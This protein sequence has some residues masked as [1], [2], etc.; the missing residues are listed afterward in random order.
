MVLRELILKCKAIQKKGFHTIVFPNKRDLV[1]LQP[2][3]K[4][5]MLLKKGTK[6]YSIVK[7]KCPRCHQGDFFSHKNNF[8]LRKSTE[9]HENCSACN[10]KYMMEPSFFFGAMFVA[11]ALTVG[12][13]LL[14]FFLTHFAFGFGL[15][16][17]FA[18]IVVVLLLTAGINLRISRILWINFFVA[19][20]S[21]YS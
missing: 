18:S 21:K 3:S 8:G 19:Y 5:T 16:G 10:L 11:Y 13:S 20:D 6:L 14:V 4:C 12:L 9:I 1:S 17:S 7:F 15:I 2:Q